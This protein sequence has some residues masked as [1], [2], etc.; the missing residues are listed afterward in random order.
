MN[1][2]VQASLA[3]DGITCRNESSV[4]SLRRQDLSTPWACDWSRQNSEQANMNCLPVS[5]PN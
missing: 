3:E 5:P 4:G 1:N 2:T